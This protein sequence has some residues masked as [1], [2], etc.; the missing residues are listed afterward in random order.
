MSSARTSSSPSWAPFLRL[1]CMVAAGSVFF[2]AVWVCCRD[3]SGREVSFVKSLLLPCTFLGC[4]LEL[5]SSF[6]ILAGRSRFLHPFFLGC[7]SLGATLK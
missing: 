3:D 6:Y 1:V 7:L 5:V 2:G 4:R